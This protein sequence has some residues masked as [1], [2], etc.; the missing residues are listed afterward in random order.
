MAAAL[1]QHPVNDACDAHWKGASRQS[2]TGNRG[3]KRNRRTGYD[4]TKMKGL[5]KVEAWT[6][7]KSQQGSLLSLLSD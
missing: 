2:N 5:K 3:A 4:E 7:V 6:L 1:D